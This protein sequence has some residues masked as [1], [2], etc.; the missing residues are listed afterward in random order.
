MYI[1][2]CFFHFPSFKVCLQWWSTLRRRDSGDQTWTDRRI[3]CRPSRR[4]TTSVGSC[5]TSW[6]TSSQSTGSESWPR[7]NSCCCCVS[8]PPTM[9]SLTICCSFL[10]T[11]IKWS[12]SATNSNCP[13]CCL[14]LLCHE[15]TCSPLTRPCG[16]WHFQAPRLSS[17]PSSNLD[18]VTFRR[19]RSVVVVL[20]VAGY[21]LSNAIHSFIISLLMPFPFTNN[22]P[23]SLSCTFVFRPCKRT[24]L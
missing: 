22:C 15:V 1:L 13:L 19:T 17:C 11:R 6:L 7:M 12:R 16:G 8:F 9:G 10:S 18:S 3:F 5:T 24:S 20:V 14:L 23:F 21:Q 2:F 4:S